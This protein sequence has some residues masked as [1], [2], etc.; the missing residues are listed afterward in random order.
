[1]KTAVQFHGTL[2]ND[3]HRLWF[4]ILLSKR[5]SEPSDSVLASSACPFG[6]LLDLFIVAVMNCFK[7]FL[8][9]IRVLSTVLFFS[10]D[11]QI[12]APPS[13]YSK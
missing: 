3:F 8:K 10:F 2:S 5:T 11:Q 12:E 9:S 13:S 4:R 7:Y 6:S 1:M